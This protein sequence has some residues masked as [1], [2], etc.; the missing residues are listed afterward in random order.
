VQKTVAP[1]RKQNI[2]HRH[3]RVVH[4]APKPKVR[5]RAER[6]AGA[7][8]AARALAAGPTVAP[9][10]TGKGSSW[11]ILL[12]FLVLPVLLGLAATLPAERMPQRMSSV[13]EQHR[14]DLAIAG[15]IGFGAV[16][17]AWLVTFALGSGGG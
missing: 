16:L 11:S 1:P 7:V 17:V 6:P 14:T 9:A 4:K 5:H 2:R 12:A 8:L 3:A 13:F 15:V 10:G